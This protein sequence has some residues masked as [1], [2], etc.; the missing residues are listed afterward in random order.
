MLVAFFYAWKKSPA[1]QQFW[2]RGFTFGGRVR[3]G[4]AAV[5]L[6]MRVC[7]L[8]QVRGPGAGRRKHLVEPGHSLDEF[9]FSDSEPSSSSDDDDDDD[10]D[11]DEDDDSDGHAPDADA[12]AV[13]EGA[14]AADDDD[15]NSGEA[16]LAV[17]PTGTAALLLPPAD[18]AA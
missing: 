7:V 8:T 4:R 17:D 15:D 13:T 6:G 12:A 10:S 9:A 2:A 3:Y 18:A 5:W 1:A 11:D 16:A 14:A